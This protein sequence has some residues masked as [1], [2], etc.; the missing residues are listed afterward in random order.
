MYPKFELWI[1]DRTGISIQQ[2]MYE[3]GGDYSLA[4]YTKMQTNINIS[5]ADVKMNLPKGVQREYPQK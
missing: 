1:S 4:T 2:K 3:Q 5:E